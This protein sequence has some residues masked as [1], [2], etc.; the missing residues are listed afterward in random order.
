MSYIPLKYQ[1]VLTVSQCTSVNVIVLTDVEEKRQISIVCDGYTR[2]QFAVRT[3]QIDPSAI[4]FR[5]EEED[6]DDNLGGGM[7]PFNDGIAPFNDGENP[8]DEDVPPEED[9]AGKRKSQSTGSML[10][11]VLCGIIHY[12]T[13]MKL[14]VNIV[15]I[16]DGQYRAVIVDATSGTQFP[17]NVTDGILLTLANKHVPLSIDANLWKYQSVPFKKDGQ[18][19]SLPINTL[20][21]PMLK[22]AFKSAIED[23]RYE[24]AKYLKEEIDRRTK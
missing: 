13:N 15:N 4:Q 20:T 5:T 7:N 16:Y 9:L 1:G 17:V 21:L 12:M 23:E 14:G 6:Q 2:L 18:G 11:E 22:N 10:P 24:Q 3:K 19:V 8:F